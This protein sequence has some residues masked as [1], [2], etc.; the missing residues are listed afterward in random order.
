MNLS[1]ISHNH[2]INT[3]NENKGKKITRQYSKSFSNIGDLI[4]LNTMNQTRLKEKNSN[5]ININNRMYLTSESTGNN[6]ATNTNNSNC[7]QSNNRVQFRSSQSSGKLYSYNMSSEN[8]YVKENKD[9]IGESTTCSKLDLNNNSSINEDRNLV[10]NLGSSCLRAIISSKSR[11]LSGSGGNSR[12]VGVGGLT[13]VN[14]LALAAVKATSITCAIT[15]KNNDDL[16]ILN[17]QNGKILSKAVALTTN[18]GQ[19]STEQQPQLDAKSSS[20][21]RHSA[22][23]I[24]SLNSL[25]SHFHHHHHNLCQNQ[26]YKS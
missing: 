2:Q 23:S 13:A 24:F 7:N 5:I 19:K 8:N 14:S 20:T 22:A 17:N 26:K 12:A 3:N 6:N 15:I 16:K 9:F 1:F 25:R 21:K 4:N 10:S 11:N 18:N